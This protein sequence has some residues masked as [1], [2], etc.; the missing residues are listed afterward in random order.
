MEK[1]DVRAILQSTQQLRTHWS[2]VITQHIGY[3]LTVVTAIWAFFL[4]AYLD[5]IHCSR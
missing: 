5:T 1:E 2:G 3:V 4:K